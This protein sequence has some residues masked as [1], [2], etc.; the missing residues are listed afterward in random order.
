MKKSGLL[1]TS[2]ITSH[3]QGYTGIKY[4]KQGTEN[5]TIDFILLSRITINKREYKQEWDALQM[6]DK[7]SWY[8]LL[9]FPTG[10]QHCLTKDF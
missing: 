1:G 8:S 7:P 9:G 2:G 5:A 4:P 6:V 10:F 3:L